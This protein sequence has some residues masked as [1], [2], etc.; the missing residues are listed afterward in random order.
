MRRGHSEDKW[1]P[2]QARHAG[3]LWQ[4]RIRWSNPW[5]QEQARGADWN[6]RTI[7]NS[8]P[9]ERTRRSRIA[10]Q[11]LASPMSL[12]ER[13][14]IHAGEEV[15]VVLEPAR[16]R[17]LSRITRWR[18]VAKSWSDSLWAFV[19]R[20]SSRRVVSV[21]DSLTPV[22]TS[23]ERARRAEEGSQVHNPQEPPNA[24]EPRTGREACRVR[25]ASGQN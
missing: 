21:H 8:Q 12:T 4:N 1:G 22:M 14:G 7:F 19:A 9:M 18:P 2:L 10:V 15:E 24:Q 11:I 13:E 3:A 5:Q 16:L 25:H 20:I 23:D 6:G 17:L